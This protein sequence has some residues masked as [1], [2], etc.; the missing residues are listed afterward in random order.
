MRSTMRRIHGTRD[1]VDSRSTPGS[2]GFRLGPAGQ[3]C[4]L[5]R[6]DHPYSMGSTY[7]DVGRR[8]NPRRG[9]RPAIPGIAADGRGRFARLVPS[10]ED[11][12]GAQRSPLHLLPGGDQG[13]R[14]MGISRAAPD[15]RGVAAGQPGRDWRFT[16]CSCC[17]SPRWSSART[18]SRNYLEDICKRAKDKLRVCPGRVESD[19][20][21]WVKPTVCQGLASVGF[22]H[23]TI[24]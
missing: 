5:T 2:D 4:A 6:C 1:V 17:C 11:L 22:T 18:I 3:A 24:V 20:V 15:Q 21:G 7:V 23:P 12:F 8:S 10:H 19:P 14:A 9:A 16:C 13:A